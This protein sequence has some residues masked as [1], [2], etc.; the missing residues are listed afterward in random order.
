MVLM[1]SMNRSGV[2]KKT[3]LPMKYHV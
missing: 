3:D 2:C 1:P